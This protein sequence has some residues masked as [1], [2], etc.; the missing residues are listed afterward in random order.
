[1]NKKQA[2]RYANKRKR[3]V[4]LAILR[5]KLQNDDLKQREDVD[6]SERIEELNEKIE[7]LEKELGELEDEM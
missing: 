3:A 7:E 5:N 4:H 6:N 2:I 1:M